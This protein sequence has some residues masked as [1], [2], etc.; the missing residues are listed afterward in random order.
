VQEIQ[1]AL[2]AISRSI[3]AAIKAARVAALE[4]GLGI[5]GKLSRGRLRTARD[6]DE[7]GNQGGAD[8]KQ[9][10]AGTSE[11]HGDSP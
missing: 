2:E 3:L 11:V 7:A 1:T 6:R 9:G 10:A 4:T 5:G 8:P